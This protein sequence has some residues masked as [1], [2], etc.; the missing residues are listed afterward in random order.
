MLLVTKVQPALVAVQPVM[1]QIL[2]YPVT[3][4]SMLLPMK[5][6]LASGIALAKARLQYPAEL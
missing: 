3:L 5:T 2:Q 6:D 1:V 4:P